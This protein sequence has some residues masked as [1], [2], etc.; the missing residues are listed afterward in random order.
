MLFVLLNDWVYFCTFIYCVSSMCG[1]RNKASDPSPLCRTYIKVYAGSIEV[2]L[3]V[4][5]CLNSKEWQFNVVWSLEAKLANGS[6][7]EVRFSYQT[8]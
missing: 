4:F 6:V 1:S 2:F 8:L 7:F 3:Y 5:A